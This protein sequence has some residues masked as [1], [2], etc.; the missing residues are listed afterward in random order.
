VRSGRTKTLGLGLGWLLWTLATWAIGAGSTIGTLGISSSTLAIATS[1]ICVS[2]T[3][4]FAIVTALATLATVLA[5]STAFA[6]AL[7]PAISVSTPGKLGGYEFVVPQGTPDELDCLDLGTVLL[8][9]WENSDYLCAVK[10]AFDL[11]TKLLAYGCSIWQQ[12]AL[13]HALGLFGPGCAPGPSPVATV[14]GKF[15]VDPSRHRGSTLLAGGTRP[16]KRPV[17]N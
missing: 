8:L 14:A 10:T 11:G 9:G 7:V 16:C 13:E 1:R 15:D 12:S 4:A 3:T 17:T 5:V 6:L 2:A